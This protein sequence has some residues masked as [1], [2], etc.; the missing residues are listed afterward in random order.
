MTYKGQNFGNV[1]NSPALL[2]EFIADYN[3]KFG[4]NVKPCH[5]CSGTMYQCWL[6]YFNQGEKQCAK[7][8]YKF[9]NNPIVTLPNG[10]DVSNKNITN[11]LA[12]QI[13]IEYPK[14]RGYFDDHSTIKLAAKI[15]FLPFS[16]PAAAPELNRHQIAAKAR[17]SKKDKAN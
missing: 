6:R 10:K 14:F 7:C 13:W 16:K 5:D 12:E 2:A 8:D 4:E 17:W 15:E 1:Y 11:E 3:A 9:K